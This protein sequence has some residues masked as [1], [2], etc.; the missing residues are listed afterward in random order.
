LLVELGKLM[1]LDSAELQGFLSCLRCALQPYTYIVIASSSGSGWK[2]AMT[3]QTREARGASELWSLLKCSLEHVESRNFNEEEASLFMEM[4][5]INE[6]F[7]KKISIT[8]GRN[9]LLLSYFQNCSNDNH[10]TRGYSSIEWVVSEQIVDLLEVKEDMLESKL[11][12]CE[13]WLM[14]AQYSFKIAKAGRF[15][16]MRSYVGREHLA[17]EVATNS[18][19][20][21]LALGFP[22]SYETF[23]RYIK[24]CFR[25]KKEAYLRSPTVQGLCF[26]E[27][28]LQSLEHLHID[29]VNRAGE[30]KYFEFTFQAASHQLGGIL[31]E[32]ETNSM[33]H[34]HLGHGV[35]GGVCIAQSGQSEWYLLLVQVSLSTYSKY[36]SKVYH[37]HGNLRNNTS[38]LEYHRQLKRK[39][40]RQPLVAE[41]HVIY[42][43]ASPA[44]STIPS[45]MAVDRKS[46]SY[47]CG[48]VKKGSPTWHALTTA[49]GVVTS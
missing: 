21:T 28:V 39:E 18:E 38:I 6:H 4:I 33:Y 43:Y 8:T 10:C 48:T 35:I 16:F 5:G 37:I 49:E 7:R 25:D 13:K 20:F 42:V 32:M 45:N 9:P 15:E 27:E 34:L 30:S 26:E 46:T 31:K 12:D 2:A 22:S 11:F 29:A 1:T 17:Y 40:D 36:N 41:D 47:W 19:T 23:I 14:Y 3:S 24:Q 44:Q